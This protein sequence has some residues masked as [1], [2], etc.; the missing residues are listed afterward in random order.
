M[1]SKSKKRRQKSV[2][3]S[4]EQKSQKVHLKLP[5]NKI[6][7]E[8]LEKEDINKIREEFLKIETIEKFKGE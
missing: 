4:S 3:Y 7:R 1:E 8:I 5:K 2:T 6:D